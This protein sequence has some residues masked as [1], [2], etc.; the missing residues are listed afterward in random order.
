MHVA[1]RIR[2][3]QDRLGRRILVE[4]VS[5]YLTFTHSTMPEWTFLGA[6]AEEADCGILLDVNNIYVSAVNHG[7]APQDYLAGLSP[8][9]IGQMHLAGHSDAGTH[10]VDTHDH[11]VPSPVW[12]LY[13][14]AVRRFGPVSTLVEWDDRIPAFEEVVAEADRARTAEAEVIGACRSPA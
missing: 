14:E 13:R 7:F 1:D 11:P 12:S 2:Q 9:R 5:S 6:V 10:L 4:N 3:V 8:E